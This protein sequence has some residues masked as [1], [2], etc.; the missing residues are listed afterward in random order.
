MKTFNDFEI[1]VMRIREAI[2]DINIKGE[3]NASLVVYSIGKCNDII[4]ALHE[5]AKEKTKEAN[6]NGKQD[7]RTSK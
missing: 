5:I 1:E 7:S 4:N 6:E 2:N 3:H